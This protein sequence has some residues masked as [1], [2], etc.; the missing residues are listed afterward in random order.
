MTRSMTY[1]ANGSEISNFY[2]PFHVAQDAARNTSAALLTSL[3]AL[4]LQRAPP[5]H[6]NTYLQRT[7]T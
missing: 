4:C 3:V 1:K 2:L 5:G 7:R 6:N